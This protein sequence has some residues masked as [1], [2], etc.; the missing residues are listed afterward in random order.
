[1]KLKTVS[2]L[3]LLFAL[4]CLGAFVAGRSPATGGDAASPGR[5]ERHRMLR[6]AASAPMQA[7]AR[8]MQEGRGID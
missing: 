7:V 6:R 5:I 1:M 4:V 3:T 8:N 2:W